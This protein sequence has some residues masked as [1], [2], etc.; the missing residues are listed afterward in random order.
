MKKVMNIMYFLFLSM[1]FSACSNMVIGFEENS[2]FYTE[3][4]KE[5]AEQK[6]KIP[7]KPESKNLKVENMKIQ[8][9]TPSITVEKKDKTVEKKN[10]DT[11]NETTF[12]YDPYEGE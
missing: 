3:P 11:E 1:L 4:K 8:E 2:V 9:F 5:L 10:E 7:S 12:S 6:E